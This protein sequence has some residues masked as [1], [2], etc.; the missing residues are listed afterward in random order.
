MTVAGGGADHL[1]RA[2]AIAATSIGG[3][4]AAPLA[5]NGAACMTRAIA[6]ITGVMAGRAAL[7]EAPAA[8]DVFSGLGGVQQ[9]MNASQAEI[10]PDA[11]VSGTSLRLFP[12]TGFGQAAV[13][14]AMQAAGEYREPSTVTVRLSPVACAMSGPGWWDIGR[15]VQATLL[16]G[17][18]FSCDKSGDDAL[19]VDVVEDSGLPPSRSIVIVEWMDGSATHIESDA[20]GRVNEPSTRNL[21]DRKSRVVLGVDPDRAMEMS[22]SLLK[23]GMRATGSW[24][25][26]TEALSLT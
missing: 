1:A 21:W 15:A 11:D 23:S 13:A 19:S 17:D 18:P 10:P 3:L 24:N 5:R 7:R 20:P 8:M 12:V 9:A 22:R 4:A 14:A 25:H 26:M 16:T 2:L 6:S